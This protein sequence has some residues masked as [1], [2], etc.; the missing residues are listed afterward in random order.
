MKHIYAGCLRIVKQDDDQIGT[1]FFP[2]LARPSRASSD[3]SFSS[4]FAET[5]ST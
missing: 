2:E 4:A 1:I 3:L 5:C